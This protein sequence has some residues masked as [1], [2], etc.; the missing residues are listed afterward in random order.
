M[1][2]LPYRYVAGAIALA[3]LLI[4]LAGC[5][6]RDPEAVYCAW[7]CQEMHPHAQSRYACVLREELVP[8]PD[9]SVELKLQEWC[10]C[11][12]WLT[13]FSGP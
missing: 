4:W 7:T 3:M 13:R 8:Q 10:H 6:V 11:Q 12:C 1:R 5:H 2:D 9:G